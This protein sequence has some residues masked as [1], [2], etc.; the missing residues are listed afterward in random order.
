M[1]K[2]DTTISTATIVRMIETLSD[3]V[4]A[5]EKKTRSMNAELKTFREMYAKETDI[6][7]L[8]RQREEYED[9]A[10]HQRG[11]IA[12]Y[13]D[14]YQPRASEFCSDAFSI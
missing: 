11:E 9:R 6:E 8:K 1:N 7:I 14:H 3:R 12:D 13:L 2:G 10:E 4:A 5:L